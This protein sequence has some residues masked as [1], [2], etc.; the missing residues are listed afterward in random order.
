MT[1]TPSKVCQIAKEKNKL[2]MVTIPHM[3]LK[4]QVDY[5]CFQVGVSVHI[6]PQASA[7]SGGKVEEI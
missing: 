5:T 6:C 2:Q 4:F 7:N 1:K 3:V